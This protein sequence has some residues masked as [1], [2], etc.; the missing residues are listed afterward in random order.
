MARDGTVIVV[1]AP[2]GAGKHTIL[3]KVMENEGDLEYSVS[4]TTRP[5]RNNEI[6]GK[7]YYFIDRVEFERRV[8]AGAFVEWAEVHG[9]LYGT[10]GSELSG[11]LASGRDILLELDVQGMRNLKALNPGVV[12]VFI[13]PPSLAALEERLRLRGTNMEEDIALR[14]RNAHAEIAQCQAFDYIIVND[15]LDEAVADLEAILRAQRLRATK[16]PEESLKRYRV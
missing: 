2:S 14:L 11:K 13:L 9:H 10:L 4:A 12:T 16:Y 7:D 15:R 1:S 8:C 5:P 3:R 6:N